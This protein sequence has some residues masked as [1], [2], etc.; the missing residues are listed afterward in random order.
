MPLQEGLT[1]DS[2]EPYQE[3]P[4]LLMY[5]RLIR[6]AL[7]RLLL[8]SSHLGLFL[9]IPHRY[10]TTTYLMVPRKHG[11]QHTSSLMMILMHLPLTLMICLTSPNFLM[12]MITRHSLLIQGSPSVSLTPS[13]PTPRANLVVLDAN[14][15]PTLVTPK[16]SLLFERSA[17]SS[18]NL[19]M[20]QLQFKLSNRPSFQVYHLLSP[21]SPLSPSLVLNRKF[22][23]HPLRT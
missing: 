16:W 15:N 6:M 2:D 4:S 18:A 22:P 7:L 8:L 9:M 14:T 12:M 13:K 1:D 11:L 5:H 3:L 21:I 19:K 10:L 20:Y 17:T 23:Y